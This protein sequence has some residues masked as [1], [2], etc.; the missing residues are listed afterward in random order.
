MITTSSAIRATK[1]N[2]NITSSSTARVWSDQRI[3]RI[4]TMLAT[5]QIGSVTI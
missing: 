2:T 1:P 4:S 5:V 3:S